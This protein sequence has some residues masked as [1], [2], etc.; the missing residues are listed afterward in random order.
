[1]IFHALRDQCAAEALGGEIGVQRGMTAAHR[2]VPPV[3]MQGVGVTEAAGAVQVEQELQRAPAVLGRTCQTRP[4]LGPLDLG[5]VSRS[6][7]E[8][9]RCV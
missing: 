2:D 6:P 1:M 9:L 3:A 5:E 8:S 7:G 4:E